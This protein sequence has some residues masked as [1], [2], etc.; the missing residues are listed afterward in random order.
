MQEEDRNTGQMDWGIYGMYL[1]AA[2]GLTWAPV[3]LG[4]LF[5][6]EAA[7]GKP[8]QFPS[9]WFPKQ[10]PQSSPICSWDGG[11]AIRSRI[12]SKPTIWGYTQASEWR[13]R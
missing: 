9:P 7:N 1:K 4:G 10:F 12:L 6:T 5:L 2:G 3:I 11:P 13:K 8:I